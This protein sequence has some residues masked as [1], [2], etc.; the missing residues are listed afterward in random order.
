M[1]TG[2]IRMT[3]MFF[4]VAVIGTAARAGDSLAELEKKLAQKSAKINSLKAKVSVATTVNMENT[5]S[6]VQSSGTAEFM[7]KGD[8][9][10]L[11]T[12]MKFL[13]VSNFEG[14]AISRDITM[15]TI[16]DGEF[17]YTVKD[18]GGR[19]TAIKSNADRFQTPDGVTTLENLRKHH[20]FKVLPDES[21]DD[22]PAYVVEATPKEGA[23]DIGTTT[24]YLARK[25]GVVL[26]IVRRHEKRKMISTTTFQDIELNPKIDPERFIFKAPEGVE[27]RDH[28]RVAKP[29]GPDKSK[30]SSDG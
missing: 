5:M 20:D 1:S 25:T 11:R 3:A 19:K 24:L 16:V 4:S 26:K 28:T 27:V 22:Q 14:E 23:P 17:M 6:D 2:M 13:A 15:L 8:K 9:I 21:I 10:L 7:R 29:S 18:R 30:D 12:E